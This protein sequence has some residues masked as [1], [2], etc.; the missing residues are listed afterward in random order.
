MPRSYDRH[1]CKVF[2][3]KKQSLEEVGESLQQVYDVAASNSQKMRQ[4]HDKLVNDLNDLQ[5]RKAAIEAKIK[6]AEAQKKV[7]LWYLQQ[8]RGREAQTLGFIVLF[9]LPLTSHPQEKLA[10]SM[11]L[12]PSSSS[13]LKPS[14][15][16]CIANSADSQFFLRA[17]FSA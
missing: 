7:N 6:I 2:I 14:R 15:K 4:M 17:L 9:I 3:K 5:R 8:T 12:I 16:S 10:F 13:G 1:G 11:V